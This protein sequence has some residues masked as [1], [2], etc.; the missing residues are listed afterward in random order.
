MFMKFYI[1]HVLLFDLL[2]LTR[3]GS[4]SACRSLDGGFV[5]WIMGENEDGK[6]SIAKQIVTEDHWS[7]LR[8]LILVVS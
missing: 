5:E 4:G 1:F 6:D 2:I 8:V 7:E 3:L